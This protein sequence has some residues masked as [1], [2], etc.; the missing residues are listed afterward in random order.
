MNE[1]QTRQDIFLYHTSLLMH[2]DGSSGMFP[3]G[4][5][6]VSG[7]ATSDPLTQMTQLALILPTT[8][9]SA[10]NLRIRKWTKKKM[11]TE[12]A[13]YIILQQPIRAKL[14]RWLL[15]LSFKIERPL[16]SCL[17]ARMTSLFGYLLTPICISSFLF[18][19]PFFILTMKIN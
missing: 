4:S 8:P 12:K 3:L 19:P 16:C 15:N 18:S 10:A 11:I 5:W 17:V 2:R 9:I 14:F 1:G 13:L 6:G 7:L